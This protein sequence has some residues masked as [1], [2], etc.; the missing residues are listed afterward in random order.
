MRIILALFLLLNVAAGPIIFGPSGARCILDNIEATGCVVDEDTMS[1]DSATK[2]PTQQSV[3]AYADSF[4]ENPMDSDGDI[5]IGGSSGA[6]AKLDSGTAGTRLTSA[7]AAAPTWTWST[8]SAKSADYTVTDTD[9]IHTLLV[10]TGSS[11]DKTMTLPTASANAGREIYIKKVDS[12]TNKVIVD[13]EGSET[14]DGDTVR[15]LPVQFDAM[16]IV[17]DG[18]TWHILATDLNPKN[19]TSYTPGDSSWGSSSA[20]G[21]Y[22]RTTTDHINVVI[23]DD[24]DGTISSVLSWANSDYMPG[25]LTVDESKLLTG[26]GGDDRI[27]VGTWYLVDSGGSPSTYVGVVFYDRSSDYV[28]FGFGDGSGVIT[29]TVPVSLTSSDGISVNF[30]LPVSEWDF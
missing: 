29:S 5:I 17:C 23:E 1:S 27:P 10:T 14:I 30:T 25:S 13:G 26:T 22:T 8:T 2:I 12:G 6:A 21:F 4:P 19:A 20:S 11:T 16:R 18:T 9:G 7:G 3:K 28:L 15:N 24:F